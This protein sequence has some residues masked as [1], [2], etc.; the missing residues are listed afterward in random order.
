MEKVRERIEEVD[1]E[2]KL[3]N[4]CENEG[5]ELRKNLIQEIVGEKERMEELNLPE[6]APKKRMNKEDKI[7]Y[8]RKVMS[9]EEV[10]SYKEVNEEEEKHDIQ[11]RNLNEILIETKPSKFPLYPEADDNISGDNQY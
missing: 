2:L 1:E 9:Q 6:K 8:N 7:I 5:D 10:S 4:I 11:K 3:G